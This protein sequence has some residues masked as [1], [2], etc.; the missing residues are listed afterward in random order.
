MR[1]AVEEQRMQREYRCSAHI[2]E[3]SV[4]LL[5]RDLRPQRRPEIGDLVRR[6]MRVRA[7]RRVVHDIPTL[8]HVGRFPERALEPVGRRRQHDLAPAVEPA[9]AQRHP[10]MAVLLDLAA[11][12]NDLMS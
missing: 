11:R 4:E 8:G 1:L 5:A 12:M 6:Q 2:D 3:Q 9:T 7:R 10:V